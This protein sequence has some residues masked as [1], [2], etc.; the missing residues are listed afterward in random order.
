MARLRRLFDPLAA[1]FVD[2]GRMTLLVIAWL[3]LLRLGSGIVL[4]PSFWR[5]PL[6]FAGIA[7]ALLLGVLRACRR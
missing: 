3:V 2:D 5:G 6:L 7:G 4:L 1:L